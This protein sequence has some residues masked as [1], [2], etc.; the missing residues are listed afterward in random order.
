M[1]ARRAWWCGFIESAASSLMVVCLWAVLAVAYPG[2][3]PDCHVAATPPSG[4]DRA[5]GLSINALLVGLITNAAIREGW[6]RQ[7]AW[8]R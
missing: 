3:L 4:S 8:R 1:T 2:S 6:A 7:K 5:A